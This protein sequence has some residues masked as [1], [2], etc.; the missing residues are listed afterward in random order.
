MALYRPH[1][2]NK[3]GTIV[4]TDINVG[5]WVIPKNASTSIDR[6]PNTKHSAFFD[7]QKKMYCV[8]RDPVKRFISGFLESLE[9]SHADEWLPEFQYIKKE[10][11]ARKQ[12][13][14][15]IDELEKM[16][17][18][19]PHLTPQS[20]FLTDENGNDYAIDIF[21][22]HENLS[23]QFKEVLGLDLG[24]H[25][26]KPSHMTKN[27]LSLLSKNDINRILSIY[28]EDATLYKKHKRID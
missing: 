3:F 7:K 4:H 25:R 19:D 27:V 16:N 26:Q 5:C 17:F 10:Q 8:L 23:V 12:L 18:Y 2:K 1:P 28:E 9:S 24:F 15:A 21:F 13:A 11:D 22:D 14:F 6:I 20:W